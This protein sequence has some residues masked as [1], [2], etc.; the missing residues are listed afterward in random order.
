MKVFILSRT[1]NI[2][3]LDSQEYSFFFLFLVVTVNWFLSLYTPYSS[4]SLMI[5]TFHRPYISLSQI[6]GN[7]LPLKKTSNQAPGGWGGERIHLKNY[8]YDH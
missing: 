3:R 5:H 1:S 8:I 7:L 6:L 2:I 4:I